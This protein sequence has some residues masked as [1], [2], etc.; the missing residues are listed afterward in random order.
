MRVLPS[1]ISA[2]KLRRSQNMENKILLRSVQSLMLDFM[3]DKKIEPVTRM[4]LMPGTL[5]RCLKDDSFGM[6]TEWSKDNIFSYSYA[7]FFLEPD[8]MGS[9]CLKCLGGWAWLD[10]DQFE[11]L[12]DPTPVSLGLLEWYGE[13]GDDEDEEEEEPEDDED[14]N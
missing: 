9:Q 2:N 3:R 13:H 1:F 10:F 7:T 14:E 4:P 12:A 8:G 11:K 6:I 5:V